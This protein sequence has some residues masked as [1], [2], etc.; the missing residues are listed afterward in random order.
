MSMLKQN[1][2]IDLSP[3]TY[4]GWVRSN[5]IENI[6]LNLYY[7]EINPHRINNAFLY[8]YQGRVMFMDV[9]C[10]P[11]FPEIDIIDITTLDSKS[12]GYQYMIDIKFR[13]GSMKMIYK[14]HCFHT[15]LILTPSVKVL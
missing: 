12:R 15:D 11:H 1:Q 8:L 6:S 2:T 7:G 13:V 3:Y 4:L 5:E 9:T 10:N 14:D